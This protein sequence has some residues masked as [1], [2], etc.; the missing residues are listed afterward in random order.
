MDRI[1]LA[2][3]SKALSPRK[4][5]GEGPPERKCHRPVILAN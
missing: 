1:V 3:D 2:P 5:G 4:L